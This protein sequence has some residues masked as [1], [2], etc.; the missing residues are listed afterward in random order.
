MSTSQFNQLNDLENALKQ[1]YF[2]KSYPEIK[3][4]REIAGIVLRVHAFIVDDLA[5]FLWCQRVVSLEEILKGYSTKHHHYEPM[6]RQLLFLLVGGKFFVVPAGGETAF[7]VTRLPDRKRKK[8]V[9][10]K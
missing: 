9:R 5:R 3:R 7:V 8:K 10:R 4:A 6:R 1:F 2:A